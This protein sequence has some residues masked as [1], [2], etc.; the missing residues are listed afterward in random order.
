MLST[1]ADH[2]DGFIMDTRPS[3]L[4]KLCHP[5]PGIA[6]EDNTV[7]PGWFGMIENSNILFGGEES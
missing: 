5:H 2:G 6:D 1:L 4:A 7:T 3:K